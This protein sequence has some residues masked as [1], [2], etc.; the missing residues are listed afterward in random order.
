MTHIDDPLTK[1]ANMD[2]IRTAMSEPMLEK[3]HELDLARRWKDERDEK[4][5]HELTRS[6]TRLVISIAAR[7]KHYGLPMGDLIQEGNIG[8]MIAAEKFD[9]KRELRFSTYASWWIPLDHSGLCLEKLVDCPHRNDVRTK[10]S[11][12]QFPSPAEQDRSRARK[13]RFERQ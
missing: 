8:L 3:E 1:A 5:L 11:V 12:F 6:Y 13:T 2:Y 9:Y 4:A 10:I 7:F